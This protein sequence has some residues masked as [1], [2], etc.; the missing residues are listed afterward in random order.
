ME[1]GM[2]RFRRTYVR[3][4]AVTWLVALLYLVTSLACLGIVLA[5]GEAM[6]LIGLTGSTMMCSLYMLRRQANLLVLR[7]DDLLRKAWLEEC[8]ERNIAIRAKA[9]QPVV[10]WLSVG[11]LMVGC[12]LFVLAG[13]VITARELRLMLTGAGAA[14]YLAAFVQLL[15]S[16]CLRR[17]WEKRM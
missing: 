7:D 5:G 15:I 16:W 4:L 2:E 3:R 13:T 10:Q 8:D 11:S 9:G 6:P 17:Y 14:L 1:K 12:L